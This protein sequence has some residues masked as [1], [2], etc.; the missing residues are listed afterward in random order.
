MGVRDSWGEKPP[1][2][3]PLPDPP[4]S[5]GGGG[6]R[7]A[8]VGEGFLWEKLYFKGGIVMVMKVEFHRRN[9]PK[10]SDLIEFERFDS[11]LLS[12]RDST[13]VA[14]EEGSSGEWILIRNHKYFLLVEHDIADVLVKKIVLKIVLRR[15]ELT[16]IDVLR[17]YSC[18]N[19]KVGRVEELNRV[20]EVSSEEVA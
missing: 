1:P 13:Y 16:A 4:H 15:E 10:A 2:K 3:P 6:G 14:L 20:I 12:L 19:W 9:S 5:P 18:S 17:L 11:I 8:V 7:V